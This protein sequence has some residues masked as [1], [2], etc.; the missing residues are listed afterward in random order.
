MECE[1]C[2]SKNIVTSHARNIGYFYICC[3]CKYCNNKVSENDKNI[4]LEC[5]SEDKIDK[6]LGD[7][8]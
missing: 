6:F 4:I 8:K 1:K 3:E 2:K 5:F 7:A